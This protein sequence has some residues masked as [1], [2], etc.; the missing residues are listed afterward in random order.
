MKTI[1][2]RNMQWIVYVAS[3]LATHLKASRLDSVKILKI[4]RLNLCKI[5]ILSSQAQVTISKQIVIREKEISNQEFKELGLL[6]EQIINKDQTM[7]LQITTSIVVI[8]L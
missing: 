4:V 2:A 1:K 3:D 8:L 6:R 5:I 7:Q